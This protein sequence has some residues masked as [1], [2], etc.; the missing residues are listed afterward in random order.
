[1]GNLKNE[2][3]QHYLVELIGCNAEQIK[4]V[5]EVKAIFDR[6]AVEAR[7][8]VINDSYYQFEPHG[9]SGIIFIAE[10]HF[11]IHTWPDDCY[12][13]CDILTCG[14][15]E[16]ERAIEVLKTGFEAKEVKIQIIARG[17]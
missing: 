3:G 8:T 11:A 2:F 14:D 10:S 13:G 4:H 6:S 7:A 15:L 16:P 17:F 5:K 9:V 12:A 1:M